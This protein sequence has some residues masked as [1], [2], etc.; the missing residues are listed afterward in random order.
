MKKNIKE[1]IT[2]LLIYYILSSS[3]SVIL[4]LLGINVSGWDKISKFIFSVVYETM[5]LLLLI[6]VFRKTL[7]KNLKEWL[8]KPLQYIGDYIK[9]W[10]LALCLMGAAN[11]LLSLFNNGAVAN[12]EQSVR[13]LFKLS[14]IL[15]IILACLVA[16][17]TE[18]LVFR[19]SFRKII[20]NDYVFIFLS[21]FVF[22]LMHVIGNAH[23]IVDWLYI[24]PY[25]I[26]GSVFAYTL[27]KSKNIMVPTSLHMIHNTFAMVLQIIV[28]VS[29][30]IL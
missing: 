16:P 10:L 27:V 15:T 6:L 24:I 23:N 8:K 14:P 19:L 21:G 7:I 25:G 28:T 4:A 26:P 22:G 30:T 18:E 3:A 20:K 5:I 17:L 13:E 12:N 9:Y 1:G 11:L 2:A 29:S